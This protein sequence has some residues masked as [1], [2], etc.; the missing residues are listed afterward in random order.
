MIA[1]IVAAV[2]AFGLLVVGLVTGQVWLAM[3]HVDGRTLKEWMRT[4]R[5]WREVLPVMLAVAEGLG[6]VLA[7]GPGGDFGLRAF[8]RSREALSIRARIPR[9]PALR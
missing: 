5:G 2:A 4:R 1:A 9:P 8:E 6:D 7:L 3:E